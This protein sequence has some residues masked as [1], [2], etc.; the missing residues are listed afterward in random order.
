MSKTWPK[1]QDEE[2]QQWLALGKNLKK[3]KSISETKE[4]N[5]QELSGL[6]DLQ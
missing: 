1:R 2:M 5:L 4:H 3:E 6:S